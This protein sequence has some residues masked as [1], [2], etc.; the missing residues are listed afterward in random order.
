MGEHKRPQQYAYLEQLSLEELE[1]IIRADAESEEKGDTDFIYAVLEVIDEKE[2]E[3]PGYQPVDVDKAW[4]EFQR[5]C[6]KR[7]RWDNIKP[8]APMR[9]A[10]KR[11]AA[12][13]AVVAA[14]FALMLTVQAAGVDVFGAIAHWTDE[15]FSFSWAGRGTP[16]RPEWAEALIEQGVDAS[17]IPAKIP[18]GYQP[19][20]LII[21]DIGLWKVFFQ[22]FRS[23][24]N[25]LLYIKIFFYSSPE[26]LQTSAYEKDSSLVEVYEF[27]QGQIYSFTNIDENKVTYLDGLTEVCVIGSLPLEELQKI[28][29]S[30]GESKP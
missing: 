13:A 6:A 20:E 17:L 30:I 11:I 29:E 3:L 21:E 28:L 19:Q 26:Y 27:G 12:A 1:G 24:K 4:E 9:L 16:E 14:V 25:E 15:V 7:E 18:E 22:P 2:R 5:Y 10:Y 23:T 8:R